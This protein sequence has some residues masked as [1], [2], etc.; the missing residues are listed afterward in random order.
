MS[1][2]PRPP[3]NP[4]PQLCNAQ[5]GHEGRPRKKVRMRLHCATWCALSGAY[6]AVSTATLRTVRQASK[7]KVCPLPVGC[8]AKVE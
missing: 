7:E 6:Q 4:T 8:P 2:A 3:L 5:F 1:G